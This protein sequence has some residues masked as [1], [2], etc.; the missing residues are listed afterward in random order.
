MPTWN[1]PAVW[2]LLRRHRG[3]STDE[4]AEARREAKSHTHI[5][6]SL[7]SKSDSCNVREELERGGPVRNTFRDKTGNDKK[8]NDNHLRKTSLLHNA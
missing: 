5:V 7:D 3:L 1:M 8:E 2:S 6:E 4:A